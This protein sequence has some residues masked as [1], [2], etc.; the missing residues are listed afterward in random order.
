MSTEL[1][2]L[3]QSAIPAHQLR[4]SLNRYESALKTGGPDTEHF[5]FQTSD[6]GL[7]S[8]I[9]DDLPFFEPKRSFFMIRPEKNKGINCR[10][11]SPGII[12]QPH[13]D[14]GRNFV[15][16]L[17]GTRRYI[18][19]PPKECRYCSSTAFQRFPFRS[20]F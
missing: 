14:G 7:H 16:T 10:F 20:I 15:V 2:S 11:G 19:L 8:W 6:N 13:Y 5:Y 18:I 3:L 17:N 1:M 12:A 4:P 9:L